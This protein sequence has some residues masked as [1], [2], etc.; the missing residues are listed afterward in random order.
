VL[1]SDDVVDPP[2]HV[3]TVDL[4]LAVGAVAAWVS[5]ALVLSAGTI[6]AAVLGVVAMVVGVAALL[7]ARR[8]SPVAAVLALAGF[9]VALV[10]APLAARLSVAHGSELAHLAAARVAVTADL[11][12]TADP[13]L[14]AAKG[15]AGAPRAAVDAHLNGVLVAGKRVDAQGSV[16]ILGPAGLWHDVLPGQRIELDAVVQPPLGDDLLTATLIA[17]SD[18]HLV[19]HPPWWQRAAGSVRTSLRAACARLPTEVAGL[20]PGLIDGDT[21]DLDPIL[22]ERFRI[23][24]LT[25]LVAVSGTNCAIVV[26]AVLLVL[27]RSRAGPW[28]CALV[29]AI[30]LVAFVVVARPSPSVLR[31]A[32]MAAIALFCLATGRQRAAIPALSATVLGL[33]VWQPELGADPGFAMSALATASLLTIAPGWAAALR[34]RRVPGGLAEAVAVSA[35]AN[36]VTAPVIAAISGRISLVSIPAN[37]LAEPVVATV[38]MLGFAAALVS[39][40][41]LTVGSLL[42]WL[43]GW[44]CR[45]LIWVADYFGGLHGATLPWPS[46][47]A[48]GLALLA[49]MLAL[50]WLARRAGSR[51]VIAAFV[52]VAVIVLIPV[53]SVVSGWPPPGWIFVACDVGQGDGLVLPAGDHSAVVIDTGPEPVAIDR[54][55]ADLSI[56]HIPLLVLSHYHLDHVGGIEGVFHGRRVDQVIT[57]PLAQP[58]AGFDLVHTTL[59]AHRMTIGQAPVGHSVQVGG[60]RLDFLGP[61]AAFRGTR[62]DPNNSSVIIRATVDGIKILLP[63]DAEIEAQQSLLDAGIDLSADVLKVPHHGSAYSD[64]RFL[65]AVH[66][67][68]GV[69]SVGADNDYGLPSPILL[70]QLARIGL[71]VL[72]TDQAGDIAVVDSDGSLSTVSRGIRASSLGL[73]AFPSDCGQAEPTPLCLRAPLSMRPPAV[74]PCLAVLPTRSLGACRASVAAVGTPTPALASSSIRSARS[75]P[76]RYSSSSSADLSSISCVTGPSV[77]L[78]IQRS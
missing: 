69:V 11:T 6:A 74:A 48:G 59:A 65:T 60:V 14:L 75:P 28:T 77:Y 13:R 32:A 16:L 38:T 27:R 15:L 76:A 62:S 3:R 22:A 23:A 41:S 51:R 37:L 71:P 19:G 26:G 7:I 25:H 50:C 33:L 39:P 56:T 78:S 70:A 8:G 30:V 4:R 58:A 10:L 52:V 47:S 24:S 44:P 54:C 67:K 18:P 73:R 53:R 42:A 49:A 43:A 57:G 34:R 31:A 61:A 17:Q 66:A 72:R 9:C 46:G 5:V 29:G 1:S 40:F 35:A 55:L 64:P 36:A 63:G 12:V 2:D 21:A 68:I 20:L 45:W